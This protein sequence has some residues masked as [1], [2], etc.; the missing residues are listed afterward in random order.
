MNTLFI[1]LTT[2]GLFADTLIRAVILQRGGDIHPL[3]FH[4]LKK[5]GWPGIIVIE[6]ILLIVLAIFDNI[7]I[8]FLSTFVVS[9]LVFKDLE[10]LKEINTTQM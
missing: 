9:W 3:F 5:V 10:D 1:L 6:I 8:L 4:I 7:I 2:I